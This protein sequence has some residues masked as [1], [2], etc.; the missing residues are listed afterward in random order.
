MCTL[1]R[2]DTN[3]AI[4][5]AQLNKIRQKLNYDYKLTTCE[6]TDVLQHIM[7]NTKPFMYQIILWI[8][9]DRIAHEIKRHA[10]DNTFVFTVTL[11]SVQKE[12]RHKFATSN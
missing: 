11:E 10:A 9:K 3:P 7:Y 2:D 12:F 5:F 6:D 1:T 8:N 4:T